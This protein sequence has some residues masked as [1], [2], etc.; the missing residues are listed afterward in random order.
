MIENHLSRRRFTCGAI[1]GALV[2]AQGGITGYQ[3]GEETA[4]FLAT[5]AKRLE[6]QPVIIPPIKL[7]EPVSLVV[8]GGMFDSEESKWIL[9]LE[10]AFYKLHPDNKFA[11]LTKNPQK[12]IGGEKLIA[13]VHALMAAHVRNLI[14]FGYSYGGGVLQRAFDRLSPEELP[15]LSVSHTIFASARSLDDINLADPHYEEE[16]GRIPRELLPDYQPITRNWAV[17]AQAV[18]HKLTVLYGIY[19]INVKKPNAISL[20]TQLGAN[21][22]GVKAN[23]EDIVK[24]CPS[25]LPRIIA[26]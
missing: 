10:K 21:L 2:T 26:T 12:S 4:K 5:V 11:A 20:Q 1:A 24:Q 7:R 8:V 9:D 14:L 25:I 16:F 22:I 19:D 3:I 23:H 15:T 6:N 18:S 17:N 13:A